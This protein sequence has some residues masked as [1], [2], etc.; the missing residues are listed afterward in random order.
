L[1]F[2]GNKRIFF[3][4]PPLYA[5]VKGPLALEVVSKGN[6]FGIFDNVTLKNGVLNAD[7]IAVGA[8]SIPV[9]NTDSSSLYAGF[10]L[11]LL[12]RYTAGSLFVQDETLVHSSA[13]GLSA[14]LGLAYSF[15]DILILGVDCHD[16]YSGL[17]DFMNGLSFLQVAPNLSAG[18]FTLPFV[19]NSFSLSF[20]FEVENIIS[21]WNIS[22]NE[23]PF[24]KKLKGGVSVDLARRITIQAGLKAL[25]PRA[26]ISM[27]FGK[28]EVGVGITTLS[29]DPESSFFKD[30]GIAALELCFRVIDL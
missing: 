24:F 2:G 8:L 19:F 9:I 29:L 27:I 26:L 4:T 28:I 21:L 7:L 14:N 30:D 23:I 5:G 10:S 6:G 20:Y 18:V 17:I 11:K 1:G 15:N 13:T 3:E 12:A 25:N 16:I 22:E